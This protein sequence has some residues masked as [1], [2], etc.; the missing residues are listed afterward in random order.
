MEK[1][2]DLSQGASKANS[3]IVH[4]GYDAKHGTLKSKLSRKGNQMFKQLNEELNF[5]FNMCGSLV[6]AFTKAEEKKLFEL[7][8]KQLVNDYNFF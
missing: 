8:H 1:D 4:G 6:L 2:S 5:G 7:F 3:G